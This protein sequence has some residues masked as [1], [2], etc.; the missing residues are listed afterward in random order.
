MY[1]EKN[2]KRNAKTLTILGFGVAKK[3]KFVFIFKKL[4]VIS[5]HLVENQT[6]VHTK[7]HY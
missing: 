5:K 6:H 4:L 7:V 2:H 1:K 3:R